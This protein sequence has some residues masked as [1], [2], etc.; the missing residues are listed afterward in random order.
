MIRLVIAD[1]HPV[2]REGLKRII[3]D[4]ADMVVVGEA[5]DGDEVVGALSAGSVDVLLLDV[6]MPGP[7]FVETMRRLRIDWPD[8]NVLVLSVH[9]EEQYAVRALRAGA[10]GYLT[11]DH[12]PEELSAAV[13]RVH[14]GGKYVSESLAQRLAA[15]LQADRTTQPHQ[16]RPPSLRQRPKRTRRRLTMSACLATSMVSRS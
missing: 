16:R 2:V 6:S 13:R 10:D 7:G 4:C 3:A 11:K 14:Q 15:D 5:V 1:D 9:S 12:S 8:V